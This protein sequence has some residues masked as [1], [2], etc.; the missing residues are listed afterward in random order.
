MATTTLRSLSL[1]ALLLAVGLV[2][3][4]GDGKVAIQGTATWN[5][6]PI[7]KGYIELQPIGEGHFASAEISNGK[8][9]VQTSPGKR[10]VKV[11]AEKVIGQT[12][13]TERIPESK[14]ILFQFVPPK[15]NS[16]SKYEVDIAANS[17]SLDIKLD[18]EELKPQ[19]GISAEDRRKMNL[20]TSGRR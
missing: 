2:G 15:Y 13:P 11:T 20:Q 18:G 10:L 16:E 19:N 6:E 4:N 7:E 1:A 8:F 3:C 12:E 5:G 17:P 14:P 9:T